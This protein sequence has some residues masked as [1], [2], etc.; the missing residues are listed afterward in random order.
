MSAV[1]N[2]I[3]CAQAVCDNPQ[4]QY[5]ERRIQALSQ[6]IEE[7]RAIPNVPS[8]DELFNRLHNF[9]NEQGW[10]NVTKGGVL[11]AFVQLLI[12]DG[13]TSLAQFQTFMQEVASEDYHPGRDEASS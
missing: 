6:A 11:L 2:L 3:E 1:Q 5:H 9:G 7:V 12:D 8:C 4:D 10:G 13:R